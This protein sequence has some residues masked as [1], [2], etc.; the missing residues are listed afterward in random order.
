M[1][2]YEIVSKVGEGAYGVVL[3]CKHKETNEIVA[4]K[5]FKESQDDEMV[6][7]TTMR[8]VA[9]LSMLKQE[10]IVLLKDAFRRKGKLYLVFEYMDQNLLEVLE[11]NPNGLPPDLVKLYIYQLV[12]AIHWCH[13]NNI[14]HRDI[15]P[16][17]STHRQRLFG[18]FCAALA[19][20][21]SERDRSDDH[22]AHTCC[23]SKQ[24]NSESA[25]SRH[26]LAED[27][28]NK[29]CCVRGAEGDSFNARHG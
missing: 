21:A 5:K 25:T 16:E 20:I 14:I 6:R 7:K 10:N 18:S 22:G 1:N 17:V 8:E 26:E 29:P 24:C 2:K 3:K 23:P 13:S 11:A 27:N 9:I 19:L 15:K 12:K 28:D 4:I